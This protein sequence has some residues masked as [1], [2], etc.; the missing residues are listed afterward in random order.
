MPYTNSNNKKNPGTYQN[1]Q[2][3]PLPPK[4]PLQKTQNIPQQQITQN[5]M[6]SS[7]VS[8]KILRR[9]LPM[10]SDEDKPQ[11]HWEDRRVLLEWV[12]PW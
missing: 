2:T 11:T 10:I 6:I 12:V 3:N 7:V 9:N 5:D 1:I 8:N 4:T